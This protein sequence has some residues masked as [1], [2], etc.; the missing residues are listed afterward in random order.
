[1]VQDGVAFQPVRLTWLVEKKLAVWLWCEQCSHHKSLD[2]V[3]LLTRFGDLTLS[4]LRRKCRCSTCHSRNVF[5]RPDWH[6]SSWTR[7]VV[8]RHDILPD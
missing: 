4:D 8:S 7:G 1:M 3:P 6:K 5:I 2:S